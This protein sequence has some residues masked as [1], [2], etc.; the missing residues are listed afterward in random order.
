MANESP[1][2]APDLTSVFTT[3][4]AELFAQRAISLLVSTYQ[5]GKVILMH[6]G[7]PAGSVNTHF[8]NFPKP[9]GIA[10]RNAGRNA[11]GGMLLIE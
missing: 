6:Y 11:P 2:Q 1:P 9:M 10:R 3:S 7:A 4:L 5:A 8:R